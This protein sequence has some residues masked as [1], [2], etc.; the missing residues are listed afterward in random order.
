[1]ALHIQTPCKENLRKVFHA[2]FIVLQLDGF[3]HYI[4]NYIGK[5]MNLT[6]N[7]TVMIQNA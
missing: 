7:I 5:N 4:W 1:M 3:S 2:L 6:M